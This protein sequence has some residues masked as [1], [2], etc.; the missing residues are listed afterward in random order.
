[1]SLTPEQRAREQIDA[2]LDQA[3]WSIQDAES[4]NLAAGR[5]VAVRNLPLDKAYGTAD[6]ILYGVAVAD[7]A[8]RDLRAG[9]DGISTLMRRLRQ[10]ILKRA[11]E[12][13]LVAQ[14]PNKEPASALLERVRAERDGARDG[15]PPKQ[16]RGR[17]GRAPV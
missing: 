3:G 10:A 9:Y 7:T 17:G 4:L 16:H 12:G 2:Q 1:M 5:G 11:F 15:K 8:V 6:Y 14:D 13:Q